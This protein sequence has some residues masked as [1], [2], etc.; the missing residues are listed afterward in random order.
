MLVREFD[1][2]MR[3]ASPPRAVQRVLFAALAPLARWLGYRGSYP[4]YDQRVCNTIDGL[5]P[6]PPSIAALLAGR[7]SGAAPTGS[8]T[9]D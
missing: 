1:D 7:M 6:L 3:L 9:P 8:I 2:T 4:E 5:Q